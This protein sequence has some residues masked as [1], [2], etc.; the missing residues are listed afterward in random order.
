MEGHRVPVG[1]PVPLHLNIFVM[2]QLILIKHSQPTVDPDVPAKHWHLSGEGQRRCMA[3]AQRLRRYNLAHIVASTEPKAME[4]AQLVAAELDLPW[5]SV[6]GLHKHDRSDEPFRTAKQFQQLVANFFVH[7]AQLIFGKETAHETLMR[8]AAAVE[9]VIDAYAEGNV[10]I[11]AHGTLIALFV[12][13]HNQMNS[14]ELWQRLAMPSFV[15]L[16]L[17]QFAVVGLIISAD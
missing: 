15:V 7:P 11:V 1:Y 14:F 10:A 9:H 5:H 13:A 16:A 3:L 8:F 2:R 6:E 4:T 17:P 12:A